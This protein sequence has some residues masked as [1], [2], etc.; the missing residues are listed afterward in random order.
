VA[1]DRVERDAQDNGIE[2]VVFRKIALK[3]VGLERAA[4]GLVLWVEVEYNPLASVVRERD[5]SIFL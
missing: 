3:V 5:L 2:S 4:A 1:L